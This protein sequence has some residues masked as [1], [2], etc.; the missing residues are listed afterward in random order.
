MLG[1]LIGHKLIIDALT[2]LSVRYKVAKAIQ[3]ATFAHG[4]LPRRKRFETMDA[5]IIESRDNFAVKDKELHRPFL[6]LQNIPSR[7]PGC[8][9][10]CLYVA[11]HKGPL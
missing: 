3:V 8:A 6:A 1:I 7:D 9:A 10:L 5:K 11:L 2:N 4:F